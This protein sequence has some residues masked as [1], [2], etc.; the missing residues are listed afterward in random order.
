MA[1]TARLWVLSLICAS[2]GA[3]TIYRT[4]SLPLGIGV[5]ALVLIVLGSLLFGYERV[6]A[7]RRQR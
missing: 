2:A 5:F 3:Y 4:T 1:K 6:H 7:K